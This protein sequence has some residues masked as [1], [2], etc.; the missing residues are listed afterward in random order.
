LI[1]LPDISSKFSNTC[2]PLFEATRNP[3]NINTTAP[4]RHNALWV[5]L[6]SGELRDP[7]N[8][9]PSVPNVDKVKASEG[10]TVNTE[11]AANEVDACEGR[12]RSA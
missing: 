7:R 11:D 9:P 10:G 2:T 6:E 3:Y 8:I 12:R 5:C 1:F 4:T